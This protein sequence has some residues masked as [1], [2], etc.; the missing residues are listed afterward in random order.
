MSAQVE[1]LSRIQTHSA[2]LRV[3]FQ[4][5]FWSLPLLSLGYWLSLNHLPAGF[6]RELPVVWQAPL[7]T[8]TLWLAFWVNALPLAVLLFGIRTLQQLCELYEKA[9][10]FAP[11]NAICYRRLGWSLMAW[12]LANA[13]FVALISVVLSYHNP[14]GERQL[15]LEFGW[16]D[17]ALL[18]VGAVIIV[19]ARVMEEAAR[20]DQEAGRLHDELAH[21]V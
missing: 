2:R 12:V 20:L 8:S 17:F 9:I 3:L 15:V 19:V 18:A 14:A 4:V 1:N 16:H 21:T 7:S 13:V 5:V 10:F 11:E 6:T